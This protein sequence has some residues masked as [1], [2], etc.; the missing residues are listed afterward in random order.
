[1]NKIVT[2]L[3]GVVILAVLVICVMNMMGLSDVV[4]DAGNT[5]RNTVKGSNKTS[6]LSNDENDDFVAQTLGWDIRDAQKKPV[7]TV[8]KGIILLSSKIYELERLREQIKFTEKRASKIGNEKSLEYKNLR[9][10]LR[11]AKQKIMDPNTVYPLKIKNYTFTNREMLMAS[12]SKMNAKFESLK[13]TSPYIDNNPSRATRQVLLINKQLREA[14][15]AMDLLKAK[16]TTAEIIELE[17]MT[18]KSGDSLN[19]ITS[20]AD[21]I[22]N[23]PIDL[24]VG[25]STESE[26]HE[27]EVLNFK[28]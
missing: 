11:E 2:S 16:L 6:V 19:R 10:I 5:I 28:D 4:S 8:K 22:I 26:Q 25:P 21:I 3:L 24:P 12:F 9:D 23:E 27:Q 14:R 7:A 1:M 13:T 18:E 20:G 15:I 17:R